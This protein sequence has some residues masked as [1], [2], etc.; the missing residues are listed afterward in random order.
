[1]SDNHIYPISC[2]TTLQFPYHPYLSVSWARS[3]SLVLCNLLVVGDNLKQ[4]A[5]DDLSSY[6]SMSRR[7]TGAEGAQIPL[8]LQVLNCFWLGRVKRPCS[9]QVLLLWNSHK[10]TP[11]RLLGHWWLYLKIAAIFWYLT[12]G[13]KVYAFHLLCHS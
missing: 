2:Q 10:L 11:P 4:T 7:G 8:Y 12:S 9:H 13:Y 5:K 3:K 6:H 1:M